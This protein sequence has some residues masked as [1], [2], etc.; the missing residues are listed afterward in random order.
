ML[1]G[2]AVEGKIS[3]RIA[4]DILLDTLYITVARVNPLVPGVH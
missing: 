2:V 4:G 1:K 3:I